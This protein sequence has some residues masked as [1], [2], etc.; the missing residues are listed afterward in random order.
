MSAKPDR[1]RGGIR[2]SRDEPART[3]HRRRPQPGPVPHA[4]LVDDYPGTGRQGVDVTRELRTLG[5]ETPGSSG[6]WTSA[7][8]GSNRGPRHGPRP[9]GGKTRRSPSSSIDGRQGPSS[10]TTGPSR[11]TAGPW[12]P[13]RS[14]RPAG[15]AGPW[16]RGRSAVHGEGRLQAR[17]REDEGRGPGGGPGEGDHP[18][19]VRGRRG[20]AAPALAG[21]VTAVLR[22]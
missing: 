19:R 2:R 6:R 17:H 10:V 8:P 11:G 14:T 5:R 1:P 12:L 16:C 4:E 15:H 9:P 7:S 18:R 20:D 13:E 22:R 21:G 3:P